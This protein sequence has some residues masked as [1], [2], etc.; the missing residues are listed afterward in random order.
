MLITWLV[1]Q[2]LIYLHTRYLGTYV[3]SMRTPWCT[4]ILSLIWYAC[5]PGKNMSWVGEGG[6]R[7]LADGLLP[8]LAS[9]WVASL[10]SAWVSFSMVPPGTAINPSWPFSVHRF[11]I[12]SGR[13]DSIICTTGKKGGGGSNYY[14]WWETSRCG[15]CEHSITSLKAIKDWK[16]EAPFGIFPA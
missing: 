15:H 4:W 6:V 1:P 3:N 16:T 11:L 13:K 2:C 10:V 5:F 14:L 8:L 7:W 12:V 9:L